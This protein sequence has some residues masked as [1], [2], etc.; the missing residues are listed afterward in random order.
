M[1]KAQHSNVVLTA[2]EGK[3]FIQKTADVCG[4]DACI[5][6]TRIMV[7][8][9]LAFKKQGWT[10]QDFFENYPSLSPEDLAAAWEY[11]RQ[12]PKEIDEAI[13]INE[14]EDKSTKV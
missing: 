2:A 10:D 5:R 11:Y 7:W 4:G 12:H 13:R 14:R 6:N 9:L 3:S 1:G 8:L